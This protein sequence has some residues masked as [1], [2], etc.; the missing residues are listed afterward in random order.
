MRN[1]TDTN[2]C[3]PG[4]PHCVACSASDANGTR[5]REGWRIVYAGVPEPGECPK[6]IPADWQRPLVT[7]TTPLPVSRPANESRDRETR[8][9]WA[10]LHGYEF[11]TPNAAREWFAGWLARVPCGDCKRHAAEVLKS[12]PIDF[13]SPAA[14]FASGVRFHNGVNRKLGKPEWTVEQAREKWLTAP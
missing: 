10:E 12:D 7:I 4:G 3:H 8:R 11:T 5:H 9:L 6:G 1:W 2:G 14:M 13:T